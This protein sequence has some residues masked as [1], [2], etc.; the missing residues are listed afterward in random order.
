MQIPNFIDTKDILSH[1]IDIITVV[2]LFLFTTFSAKIKAWL[3]KKTNEKFELSINK[4]SLIRDQLAELRALYG[5]DRVLLLQLHN[6]QYYFSGDGAD[7]LTLTHFTVDV[8]IAVPD[9]ASARMVNIPYTYLPDL[10]RRMTEEGVFFVPTSEMADPYAAQML[11]MDGVES[12][13]CGPI[14]D[15]KGLWRGVLF[16]CFMRSEEEKELDTAETHARRIA[17]LLSPS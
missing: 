8:G 13:I 16:V 4:N 10:F 9:R 15:R 1:L 14:K 6:G 2:A 11:A 17:D 3:E 5:A 12:S 7:K